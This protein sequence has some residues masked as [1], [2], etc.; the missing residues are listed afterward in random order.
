MNPKWPEMKENRMKTG[1]GGLDERLGGG[2]PSG[3][4][5]LVL[6]NSET[7]L[8]MFCQQ[9]PYNLARVGHKVFY[10]TILKEP[11]YIRE[12]MSLYEWATVSFEEKKRWTFV[13]GC[14]PRIDA[15]L[16]KTP[17]D[18]MDSQFDLSVS[19]R[20]EILS[21][22]GNEDVVVVDS[23]SDVLLTQELHYVVELLEILSAQVRRSEGL[24]F[25]PLIQSMHDAK[26]I[27]TLSH[28]ADSVIE[29]AIGETYFEG[30][31]RFWK[32]R[33]A[34]SEPLFLPFS[35][36]ERGIMAETFKRVA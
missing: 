16:L 34:R 29:L 19:I 12:E 6:S 23:L 5:V 24:A 7:A 15:L 26:I 27:A 28:L 30:K 25:L 8:R 32:M 36:T 21:K 20:T 3:S 31:I 18:T 14:T 35:I 22:L 2:L 10:L 1:I 4:L 13:D 17:N 9:V 11:Q 33:R